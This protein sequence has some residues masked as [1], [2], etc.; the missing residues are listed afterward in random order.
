MHFLLMLLE[1]EQRFVFL[2]EQVGNVLQMAKDVV[3]RPGNIQWIRCLAPVT[4]LQGA[5]QLQ[6]D[7]QRLDV[8]AVG[9]RVPQA[10]R[11][12]A[13]MLIRV[14]L[15]RVKKEGAKRQRSI[16]PSYDGIGSFR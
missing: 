6:A 8:I 12:I 7:V 3:I 10:S 14:L 13:V 16:T 1:P 11:R 4:S 2:P 5:G 15:Q 9:W